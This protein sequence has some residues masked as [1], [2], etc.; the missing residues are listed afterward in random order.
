MNASLTH[1]MLP[2]PQT[3]SEVAVHRSPFA[4]RYTLAFDGAPRDYARI[5][6]FNLALTILTL[7]LYFPWARARYLRFVAQHTQLAGS[8]WEFHGQASRMAR[9]TLIFG[10]FL[11]LYAVASYIDPLSGF[12]AALAFT[13]LW[14]P[15]WRQATRFRLWQTSW[16]GLR[17]RLHASNGQAYEHVGIALV[18]LVF[19]LAWLGVDKSVFELQ[20]TLTW[21]AVLALITWGALYPAIQ[22]QAKR[23]VHG[24]GHGMESSEGSGGIHLGG[25]KFQL[26]LHPRTLFLRYLPLYVAAA[27]LLCGF[28]VLVNVLDLKLFDQVGKGSLSDVIYL[29]ARKEF[30]WALS[31]FLITSYVV[32]RSLAL[33][34][35]M[36][37]FMRRTLGVGSNVGLRFE[38]KLPWAAVLKRQALNT[39]FNLLTLGLYWPFA[40]MHMMKLRTEAVTVLSTRPL[41]EL[42]DAHVAQ[43]P[44]AAEL[45]A[46]MASVDMG[47]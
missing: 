31:P 37:T 25:L 16:R 8:R 47:W 44:S 14:P 1:N 15:V 32:F 10:S 29:H 39:A 7:G 13:L 21:G 28:V 42:I 23:L 26:A 12:I 19:P 6:A 36:P 4:H 46:D 3:Q 22:W 17:L 33:S 11:L 18:L 5:W 38:I 43:A 45:A 40:R 34:I 9:P 24:M 35:A 30:W 27:V 2:A 20:S 41:Y